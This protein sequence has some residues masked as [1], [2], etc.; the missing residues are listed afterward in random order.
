M[1]VTENNEK[2]SEVRRFSYKNGK[3]KFK[4]GHKSFKIFKNNFKSKS[5]M[6]CFQC[7]REGHVKINCI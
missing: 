6:K 2:K 4:N 1:L 5:R 3:P 7:G